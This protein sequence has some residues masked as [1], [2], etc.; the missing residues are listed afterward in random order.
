MLCWRTAKGEQRSPA[1][2]AR[3]HYGERL[4]SFELDIDDAPWW[5]WVPEL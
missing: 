1:P 3:T 4:P 2:D 5:F